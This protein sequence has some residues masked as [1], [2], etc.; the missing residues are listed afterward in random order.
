MRTLPSPPNC[1]YPRCQ[2]LPLPLPVP[3]FNVHF[4][5]L[6]SPVACRFQ[7]SNSLFLSLLGCSPEYL[8]FL[9][10]YPADTCCRCTLH[11]GSPPVSEGLIP[12]HCKVLGNL[13]CSSGISWSFQL[14]CLLGIS[15]PAPWQGCS[16]PGNFLP[17][18][19]EA[20]LST[21]AFGSLVSLG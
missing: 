9:S 6:L 19:L 14:P 11:L 20:V 3:L 8:D 7:A 4:Q 16:I 2:A 10:P 17:Q 5:E 18:C 21:G 13:P 1:V 15:V 12:K